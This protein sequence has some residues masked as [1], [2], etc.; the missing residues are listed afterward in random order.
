MD[1]H[2]IIEG[3]EFLKLATTVDP[4]T[5]DRYPDHAIEAWLSEMGYEWNGQSW[6]ALD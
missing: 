6:V 3:R 2:A 4:K 5:I 1:E